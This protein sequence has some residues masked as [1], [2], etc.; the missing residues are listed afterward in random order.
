MRCVRRRRGKQGREV[1]PLGANRM[2]GCCGSRLVWAQEHG[3]FHKRDSV[4]AEAIRTEQ[5]GPVD[6]TDVGLLQEVDEDG[7][8]EYIIL[9]TDSA[10]RPEERTR[11]S[12]HV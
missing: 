10:S 9:V 7:L 1:S 12:T 2:Y 11:K 4:N 6:A 5:Y 8:V 3:G